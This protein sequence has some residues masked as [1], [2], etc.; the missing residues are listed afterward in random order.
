MVPGGD[1]NY[2]QTVFSRDD[3]N[4]S[5]RILRSEMPTAPHEAK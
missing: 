2:R 4:Q 3:V 1:D 5:Y